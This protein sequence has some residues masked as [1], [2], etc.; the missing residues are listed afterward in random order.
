MEDEAHQL[1][2]V[3]AA[4][5]MEQELVAKSGIA[6]AGCERVFAGPLHGVNPLRLAL[7]LLKLALGCAQSLIMLAG[8]RP[9]VI[10]LTG[11]WANLPVALAARLLRIPIVIY[12]PDIEPGLTIKA[13]Q[14]LA[15][16]I[17][18]TVEQS[19]RYFEA[20]KTVLTGYPL[21]GNRLTADRAAARARFGLA[22]HRRTLLVFGGSRGARNINIALADNLAG[23]LD[24]GLQVIHIT[25]EF[26]WEANLERVGQS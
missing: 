19:V 14:P 20:G 24:M 26:D 21:Q 1:F 12:L 18:I 13:L 15:D 23:L 16:R 5:G 7:S 17:A 10:L 6:F 8:L 4:G 2:F 22:A 25:G 3:G 11:G 9:Q